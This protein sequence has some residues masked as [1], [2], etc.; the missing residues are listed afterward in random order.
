MWRAWRQRRSN[1]ALL[2]HCNALERLTFCPG[3]LKDIG[4]YE[5]FLNK[6]KPSAIYV[7]YK[8]I[9]PNG[10][11]EG[12]ETWVWVS[13]LMSEKEIKDENRG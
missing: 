7:E 1:S 5:M 10:L 2:L 4:T 6:Q 3:G 12:Y 13:E 9:V 8:N 11:A